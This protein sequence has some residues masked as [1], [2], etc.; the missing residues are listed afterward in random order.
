MSKGWF[1]TPFVQSEPQRIDKGKGVIYGAKLVAE[2]EAKGH[3]LYVDQDFLDQVVK[4]GN[5]LKQGIKARFGHPNMCSTALGT[6]LGRWKG[7]FRDGNTVRANLFL[8]NTAKDTPKGDLFTYVLN[9]AEQEPDMFGV[10]LDFAPD[11]DAQLEAGEYKDTGLQIARIIKLRGA[12]AVDSPAATD[13]MFSRFSGE[14]IAGQITS[15][16]D[17]NPSI[18]EQLESNP[19]IVEALGRYGDNMDG[20]MNRYRAYREQSKESKMDNKQTEADAAA[21]ALA[22]KEAK[23]L[24]LKEENEAA[25]IALKE[26]AAELAAKEEAERLRL[27][28]EKTPVTL[29]AER[30]AL[31]VLVDERGVAVDS[32][33]TELATTKTEVETLAS[34]AVKAETER[35]DAQRKLAAIEAGAETLSAGAADK[36]GELTSWQKAQQRT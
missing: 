1:S 28:Q 29:T 6:F 13:G 22:A 2:G 35:D 11:V 20:F 32:L 30:D 31:K 26:K 14:T 10:S 12:D 15:F 19:A 3:E 18:W 4:E 27:E 24:K 17:S 8:S 16:L 7:F 9:M 36:A 34:R 5:R 33:T 21:K 25:E 23:E